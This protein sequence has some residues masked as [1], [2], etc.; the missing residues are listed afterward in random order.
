[1]RLYASA[2]SPYVRKVRIALIELGL[3][4]QVEFVS[5]NPTE[6]EAYRQV[7]PLGKIPALQ[8]D[9]GSVIYDS[10]VIIDWLDQAAGGG[11]LIPLIAGA[12]NTEL[13]RHALANGIIDAAFAITSELRR[14][15]EQRSA[16]WIARWSDAIEAASAALPAE[17]GD[18][19][20]LATITAV[21]AVDY[22]DFRLGSL[23]LDT[24]GLKAWREQIGPRASLDQTHPQLALA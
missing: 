13:R 18:Q 4:E 17:L 1:M 19:I 22:V 16:F 12:R 21:T 5:A 11:Q 9:D 20:T 10:L 23:G 14:P 3:T 7:N 15:E 6:D 8:I 24:S 2:P